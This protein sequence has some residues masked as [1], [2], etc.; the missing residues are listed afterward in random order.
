[1]HLLNLRLRIE[2]QERRRKEILDNYVSEIGY[3]L[4]DEV[5][6]DVVKQL[7]TRFKT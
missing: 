4:I 2:Q 6:K 1:M 7:L 3:N 5:V